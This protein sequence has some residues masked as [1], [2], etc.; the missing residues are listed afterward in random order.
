MKKNI[1]IGAILVA[2]ALI[3]VPAM[4]VISSNENKT[5][6]NAVD[7][8]DLPTTIPEL[9]KMLNVLNQQI[10][11]LQTKSNKTA[12]EKKEQEMLEK[13]CTLIRQKI[14]DLE[15]PQTTSQSSVSQSVATKSVGVNA[16]K[17]VSEKAPA[18]GT[19]V[20][21]K[22]KAVTD[23]MDIP[24]STF[25]LAV[26]GKTKSFNI[27]DVNDESHIYGDCLSKKNTWI[28]LSKKEY[29]I[30]VYEAVNGDTILRA[31]F[32]VCYARNKEDKTRIG[33]SCTPE[34]R[35]SK[36]PFTISEI[37]DAST[38][39]H[40]FAND[41]RGNILAYGPY[42]MR[43]RLTGSK[44]PGNNSIGIHGCGGYEGRSNS[45]SVPGR[46]SEGC[47]RLRDND[48]RTLRQKYCDVGTRVF[49]KPISGTGSNRYSYEVKAIKNCK[50]FKTATLGNPLSGKRKN[51]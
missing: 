23:G 28:V 13:R 19:E 12:E 29:R 40:T 32:P 9:Q 43:L 33:D 36:T 1:L 7:G 46:D 38:W 17:V 18:E 2:G 25:T 26:N 51:L 15:N 21:S 39:R 16:D 8:D 5:C 44:V 49:I 22:G 47:I 48:L 50:G 3:G 27:A 41:P 24:M 34:S 45:Y 30:Y 31:T 11:P 6:V 37:K 20:T 4:N 14:N 42:F 35:D 10:M